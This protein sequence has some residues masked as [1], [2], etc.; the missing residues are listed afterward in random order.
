MPLREVAR[1]YAPLASDGT[2]FG[3]HVVSQKQPEA[4]GAAELVGA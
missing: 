4:G 2:A 3:V 1:M